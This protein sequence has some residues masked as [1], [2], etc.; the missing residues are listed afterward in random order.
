MHLPKFRVRTMMVVVAVAGGCFAIAHSARLYIRRCELFR[1]A[2]DHLE[3]AGPIVIAFDGGRGRAES[4]ESVPGVS[5]AAKEW[6]ARM[7]KKYFDA[8]GHPW[9][10]VERDPPKPK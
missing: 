2:D 9:L 1:I 3:L 7:A 6:H 4:L 5:K 10:P 8:A